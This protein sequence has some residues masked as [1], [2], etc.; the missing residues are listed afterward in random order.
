MCVLMWLCYAILLEDSEILTPELRSVS[1]TSGAGFHRRQPQRARAIR[2]PKYRCMPLFIRVSNEFL[3]AMNSSR[4]GKGMAGD[5]QGMGGGKCADKNGH[6]TEHQ[7]RP[8]QKMPAEKAR[9]PLVLP[10]CRAP[11][12][13]RR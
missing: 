10:W 4:W 2:V 3:C 9:W 8:S 1:S 6:Y 11:K 5:G 12:K 13:N 7:Q